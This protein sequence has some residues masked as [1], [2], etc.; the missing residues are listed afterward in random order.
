MTGNQAMGSSQ[1]GSGQGSLAQDS[2][3]DAEI[4]LVYIID[5]LQSAWK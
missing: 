4:S 1:E 3:S 5:F 2:S